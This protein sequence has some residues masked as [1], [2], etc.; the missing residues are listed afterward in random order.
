MK[1]YLVLLS[2]IALNASAGSDVIY[3][4]DN[5]SEVFEYQDPKIREMAKSTVT[6]VTSSSI[7]QSDNKFY[8]STVTFGEEKKTCYG[9]R[10]SDQPAAGFCS[11][12]LISPTKVVTAG[13]CINSLSDCDSTYFVF[14]YAMKNHTSAR[15]G[16]DNSQVFRC[17]KIL[18]R[19]KEN[20]GV[21]Y[22]VIELDR[23]VKGRMPLEL[24]DNSIL[25]TKSTLVV[26][27][28]PAG[29]PTKITDE[30]KVREI[31][32]QG[33]YFVTNLDTYG[34]NS[35]SAVINAK[36]YRVEGIL[37][38]GET[39]FV[40]ENTCYRSN[41]V[42]ENEGR[43]EEVT[44]ITK[45]SENGFNPSTTSTTTSTSGV[46]YVFLSSDDTCN[47]FHGSNYIREVPMSYCGNLDTRYVWLRTY[48]VC[49]E[50]RGD[51]YTRT[52][53]NA[54]CGR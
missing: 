19:T 16:F 44:L 8:V 21:D 33:G 42:G 9:E 7:R 34:G 32:A 20:K 12:F 53:P 22:A 43:G 3:G 51:H 24:S 18:G 39:D 13:H 25:S 6:L 17:K 31:K 41:R 46:R 35:G 54:Y 47:E 40:Y 5:R 2:M 11:G 30:G 36:T 23:E 45:I 29:L 37:I 52:V 38:R 10:F 15:V 26:I 48:H 14:D 27:G 50:F 49:Y 28:N 1:A 4:K